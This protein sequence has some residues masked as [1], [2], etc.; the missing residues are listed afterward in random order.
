MAGEETLPSDGPRSPV[1]GLEKP[2][3]SIGPYV[4]RSVL[5][6]GGFGTVWMAERRQP[7]VQRVA[8]KILRAGMDTQATLA[9]FEQERQALAMM[10]HPNIAKVLDGGMTPAGRP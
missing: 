1:P 10:D 8:V 6:S 9:R 4:L 3:D 2:G 5:G 7:F